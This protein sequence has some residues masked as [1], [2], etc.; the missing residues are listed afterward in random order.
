LIVLLQP[1]QM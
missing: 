1:Y